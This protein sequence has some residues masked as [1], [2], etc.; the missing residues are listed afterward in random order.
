MGLGPRGAALT[1][2]AAAAALV[3]ARRPRR[4]RRPSPRAAAPASPGPARVN[5]PRREGRGAAPPR[6]SSGRGFSG[7]LGGE[8]EVHPLLVFVWVREPVGR[9]RR[10]AVSERA[11]AWSR[12]H[13]R[14]SVRAAPVPAGLLAGGRPGV[15]AAVLVCPCRSGG[16]HAP[17]FAAVVASEVSWASDSSSQASGLALASL[18]AG[19]AHSLCFLTHPLPCGAPPFC[20][21]CL[22]VGAPPRADHA[23]RD[24]PRVLGDPASFPDG[25][26]APD[27]CRNPESSHPLRWQEQGALYPGPIFPSSSTGEVL[28]L[29]HFTDEKT[30]AQK[31]RDQYAMRLG[32]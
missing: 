9:C 4:P 5:S 16:G 20:L 8:P 15:G 22:A 2:P 3:W 27:F 6:D 21:L 14:F 25:T 32:R 18:R 7:L 31:C 10:R 23:E 30:E 29:A 24:E 1:L 26:E 12:S 28:P 17:C 13:G 19:G 11:A